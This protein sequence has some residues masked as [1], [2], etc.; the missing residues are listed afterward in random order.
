[1]LKTTMS[2]STASSFQ[3]NLQRG[4]LLR[5]QGRHAE[6]EQRFQQAI[7][8]QPTNPE[9]YYELAFCYCNWDGHS[10]K[11]LATIDRAISLA[12]NRAEFFALRAWIL[13][14]LDKDQEAIHVAEQALTLNPNSILALNAQTRACIGLSD[15]KLAEENARHTLTIDPTNET[16]SNFLAA[17]L[18]QQGK[19]QESE[20]ISANL[21]A[22]VPDNPA[23]QGNAGWSAL[24]AGDHQR[25][26]QHFMEALRLDPDYDYARK[27]L[28]HSFNSRV[29]I[30]RIY[31]QFIAWLGRHRKGMRYFFI[32]IVYVVYRLIVAELRT[33]FGGEGVHWAFVVVALYFVIFGFG[34][35]FANLFLLLDPFARHALTRKEKGWSVFAGSIFA[36]IL[37]YEISDQ[38]WPQAAVLT[39]IPAFFLW[40]VLYPRFQNAFAPRSSANITTD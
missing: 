8:E 19:I 7:A 39:A 10:P 26:N 2:E 9:G 21:L 24:Q 11:A 4:E 35:S 18:R 5:Q 32:A 28:L 38:A 34:R 23:A 1:M 16:A 30:Y 17:A 25:A 31:F 15:W 20:A 22:L 33:Q 40:G 13:G 6:A 29:W 3:A 14:N 36:L 27:G 37:G 12:P